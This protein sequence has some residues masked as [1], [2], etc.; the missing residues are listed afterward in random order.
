MALVKCPECGKEISDRAKTCIGCGF[1]LE[2]YMYREKQKAK[3]KT[4]QPV[5]VNGIALGK[6][7]FSEEYEQWQSFN[8]VYKHTFWGAKKE[9]YCP[10]C[11]SWDCK[12]IF[13]NRLICNKCGKE[14]C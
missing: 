9:V 2:N 8:G 4:Y 3:N 13:E 14:F 12:Y 1:P 10:R 11:G 6:S 5:K 7:K